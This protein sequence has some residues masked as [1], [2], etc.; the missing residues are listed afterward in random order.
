VAGSIGLHTVAS[1]LGSVTWDHED[2]PARV[3]MKT[4]IVPSVVCSLIV[5]AALYSTTQR[6][7]QIYR[8]SPASQLAVDMGDIAPAGT[9][10][11]STRVTEDFARS[12]AMC[13]DRYGTRQVAAVPDGAAA[14]V[15]FDLDTP[16]SDTWPI[17]DER[18]GR[19]PALTKEIRGLAGRHAVILLETF[20]VARLHL[21]PALPTATLHDRP[22]MNATVATLLDVYGQPTETCGPFLVIRP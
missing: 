7:D 3:A 20:D 8:D 14:D 6:R 19:S 18:G 16:L 17:D 21:L 5:L 10:I 9:G 12:I 13:A 1:V 15:L 4:R 22:V 2:R 11:R